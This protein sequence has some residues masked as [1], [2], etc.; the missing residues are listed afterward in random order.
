MGSRSISRS[1]QANQTET[2]NGKQLH[3]NIKQEP[4]G[5]TSSIRTSTKTS[6]KDECSLSTGNEIHSH[7]VSGINIQV[8]HVGENTK[9]LPTR[10]KTKV[11]QGYKN[12]PLS[13]VWPL[14]ASKI[15]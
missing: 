12:I 5:K 9:S 3:E 13:T 4:P 2:L 15:I 14:S 10:N 11:Q 7:K 8:H 1:S 6:Q